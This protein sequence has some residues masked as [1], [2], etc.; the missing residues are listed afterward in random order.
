MYTDNLKIQS[1]MSKWLAF[2]FFLISVMIIVGGLTRLTDSG[3]SIT[4]WQLFS[5]IFPPLN[6]SDWIYYFNL[7]KE[8][9]EFK[10]QNFSMTMNEFKVIFWWEWIHR[11]LGRL[12]GLAFLIPL[13]YFSL[14]LN[15]KNLIGLY[16]IFFLICFQ[17]FIGW[18]MV[19]S[20]LVDRVDVSHYR[21]SAHLLIAFFI[22]SLIFWNYLKLNTFKTS[23]D[24]IGIIAP[25]IFLTLVFCQIGIGAFVSGM[26]A[27]TI[28]NSWPL[29][30]NNYFPDDNDYINLFKLSAFN[31]PS[32][33]QFMHRNLAYLITI[34]YLYLLLKIYKKKLF[35]MY[36]VINLLGI[37]LLIQIILGVFTLLYGAQ[38]KFASMH[39]ISSIFL[40]SSSIY[41]LFLNTKI[42]NQR[43]LS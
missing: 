32:L 25:A 20:G 4:Q 15:I 9:P 29:M 17:G 37:L 41:L 26:D 8:I 13:I 7:Y 43:L 30:G 39:Q 36:F 38:I 2:M 14:K 5:G 16:S 22:L 10:L 40:V 1:Q 34:Y 35:K 11:F 42:S 28:Y 18:Y 3:L 21:L 19:S 27:G 12:I 31:D 23:Y 24:K 33:V 6:Q